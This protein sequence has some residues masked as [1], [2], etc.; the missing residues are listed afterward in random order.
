MP[1]N[2]EGFCQ[3]ISIS[4]L[5]TNGIYSEENLSV[6]KSESVRK[7]I[8]RIKK[9]VLLPIDGEKV[10]GNENQ[11][12]LS[13]TSETQEIKKEILS[14]VDEQSK[15]KKP[16]LTDNSD[17]HKWEKA[18]LPIE[19]IKKELDRNEVLHIGMDEEQLDR[20]EMLHIDMD[21]KQVIK[22]NNKSMCIKNKI[23][24]E[25]KKEIVNIDNRL[26]CDGKTYVIQIDTSND[27]SDESL[28]EFSPTLITNND[29]SKFVVK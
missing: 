16:H 8:P 22:Y 12:K 14:P 4:Q 19:E 1:G 3:P 5:E 23:T 2:N 21:E 25:S 10:Q 6:R 28:T 17:I 13:S 20:N 15:N 27:E 11:T 24:Q 7:Y 9:K 18:I 29:T 26:S